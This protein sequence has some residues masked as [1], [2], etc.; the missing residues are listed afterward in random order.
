MLKELEVNSRGGK[1]KKEMRAP[2]NVKNR[3]I[4]IS[5]EDKKN[6]DQRRREQNMLEI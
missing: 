4:C 1:V 6:I 2:Q 3:E 5:A